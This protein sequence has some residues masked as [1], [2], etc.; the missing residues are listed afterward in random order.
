MEHEQHDAVSA[1]LRLL[2]PRHREVLAGRYGLDGTS[3]QSREQI[4]RRL[5]IDKERSRQIER[6]SLH[7]L[8]SIPPTMALAA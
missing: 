6:E 1:L 7:R 3:V 5:G 2:P 4:G 8:P